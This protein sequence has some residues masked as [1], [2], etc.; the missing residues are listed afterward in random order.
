MAPVKTC[1]L[2]TFCGLFQCGKQL[3][4]AQVGNSD[5]GKVT[6]SM[7]NDFAAISI[8]MSLEFGISYE[9]ASNVAKMVEGEG[10]EPS[11]AVPADLQSDPFGHS[12]TPP[13]GRHLIKIYLL[14]K[15]LSQVPVLTAD[16]VSNSSGHQL[17]FL[18]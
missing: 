12:G 6:M 17:I 3:S 13:R 18:C 9:V 2:A 16:N 10:F 5:V 1:V 11:K 14:V 8:Y 15:Q 7:C 4:R